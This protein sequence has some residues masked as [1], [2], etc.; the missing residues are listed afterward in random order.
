MRGKIYL[1]G[2]GEIGKG[3]TEVI[4]RYILDN[5]TKKEGKIVF[6]GAAAS[7]SEGYFRVFSK[8]YGDGAVFLKS[9][10]SAG[11]FRAII[12]SAKIVYLGGGVTELL[13]RKLL[14]WGARE[15][16]L[17]ALMKGVDFVGMSAG[18]Y[19]LCDGYVDETGDELKVSEG[20]G[21]VPGVVQAHVDEEKVE[22]SKTIVKTDFYPLKEGEAV[23]F[24]GDGDIRKIKNLKLLEKM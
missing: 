19:V 9:D 21:I 24:D 4:D 18:A 7:D 14:E 22:L 12:S 17:T 15:V 8:V 6:I 16:F 1:I 5:S 23:V 10:F 13:M 2:G 3:E 11:R 20:L